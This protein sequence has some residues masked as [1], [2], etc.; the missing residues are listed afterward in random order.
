MSNASL[1]AGWLGYGQGRERRERLRNCCFGKISRTDSDTSVKCLRP[2]SQRSLTLHPSLALTRC[3]ALAKPSS[4][5]SCYNKLPQTWQLNVQM[6]S[7]K[8]LEVSLSKVRSAESLSEPVDC[9]IKHTSQPLLAS[10][11]PELLSHRL[12]ACLR[13]VPCW[14]SF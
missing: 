6:Y 1:K 7:L 13:R 9:R 12:L 14:L 5:Y 4:S 10:M 11:P 8:V 2:R 3:V